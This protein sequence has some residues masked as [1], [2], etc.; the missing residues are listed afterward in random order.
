MMEGKHEYVSAE[1]IIRIMSACPSQVD[2]F[3]RLLS[4]AKRKISSDDWE[5]IVLVELPKKNEQIKAENKEFG[6]K[7]PLIEL[8]VYRDEQTGTICLY[9]DF[10]Q[11]AAA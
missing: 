10:D 1:D 2:L 6:E 3:F 11:A 8:G 4:E 9:E 5:N 7:E